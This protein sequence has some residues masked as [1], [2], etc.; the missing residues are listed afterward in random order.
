MPIFHYKILEDSGRISHG[1]TM[2]PFD[3][4]APA[5]RYL[6]RQGCVVLSI[7]PLNRFS[8]LLGRLKQYLHTIKRK[9]LAE[10]LNN[11]AMRLAAGVPVLTAITD[12]QRDLR[13]PTLLQILRFLTVDIENGQTLSQAMGRHPDVFSQPVV[14]MCRLG[15]ETGRLGQ[16]LRKSSEH[17]LHID[18]IVVTTRRA[19][20]HPAFLALAVLGVTTS[21]FMIV[22]PQLEQ[23]FHEM[24]V[25][26]PL[27][28]RML[29]AVSNLFQAC[30]PML[31]AFC[32]AA[33]LALVLLRKRS[34]R[35]RYALDSFILRIPMV[36]TIIETSLVAR[37]SEYLGILITA[38]IGITR[39]VDIISCTLTN[40]VF[41][42]RFAAV[43]EGVRNG[44]DLSASMR[45]ANALNPFAIRMIAVGEATGRMDAQ[46]LYVAKV[47]RER[48]RALVQLLTQGLE[49]V[50]LL[51][52]GC[53]FALV[54]GGILLPIHDLIQRMQ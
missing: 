47:H 16:M 39:T 48:L 36:R 20:L 13:N 38:G 2:L 53:I 26:L 9:E 24:D 41:E 33:L 14:S 35:I 31:F 30:F 44:L 50:M 4:I 18:E 17:L 29:F 7:H 42:Q 3:D 25:E 43:R 32:S 21:W 34:S 46:F 37:V 22:V 51:F 27:L 23:L 12:V 1:R 5:I 19:L 15:E 49:P 52:L 40:Q 10:V 8:K 54:M 45:R 11:M 28:T 6:E